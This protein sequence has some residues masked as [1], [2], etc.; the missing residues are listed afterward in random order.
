[1]QFDWDEPAERSVRSRS[2]SPRRAAQHL[3]ADIANSWTCPERLFDYRFRERDKLIGVDLRARHD[4][5]T[6]AARTAS[7]PSPRDGRALAAWVASS[8]GWS[9][10]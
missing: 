9:T 2:T 3:L 4:R 6:G 10:A 7:I 8:T 1:V 5:L